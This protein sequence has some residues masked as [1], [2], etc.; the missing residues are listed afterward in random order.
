MIHNDVNRYTF[1]CIFHAKLTSQI[2][3]Q[4]I[5]YQ[6]IIIIICYQYPMLIFTHA[7]QIRFLIQL[8]L[9]WLLWDSP[10]WIATAAYIFHI[11][12]ASRLLRYCLRI[13]AILCCIAFRYIDIH[14]AIAFRIMWTITV[15]LANASQRLINIKRYGRNTFLHELDRTQQHAC[16]FVCCRCL[17]LKLNTYLMFTGQFLILCK[18]I[19]VNFGPCPIVC[20]WLIWNSHS[21]SWCDSIIQIH[22]HIGLC[23]FLSQCIDLDTLHLVCAKIQ[24]VL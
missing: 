3:G 15:H 4:T 16:L 2:I 21:H 9:I 11:V 5:T 22:F 10:S 14:L 13:L 23:R 19:A 17:I 20:L 18:F 8:D 24:C 7:K 12:A 1:W 6:T